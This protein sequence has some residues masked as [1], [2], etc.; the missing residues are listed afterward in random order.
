[1]GRGALNLIFLHGPPA[2][3]KLTIAKALSAELGWPVFHNHLVVD[4]LTSVFEFGSEPFVRLREDFWLA[5]FEAAATRGQSIIFTFAPERTVREDFARRTAE[6][7]ARHGGRVRFIRLTC[8]AE[9]L[10]ARVE[11]PDR[12]VH[13]KLRSR[14]LLAQLTAQGAFDC[15]PLP[16]ELSVDTSVAS[17]AEAAR[18]ISGH[19][20]STP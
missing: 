3:G 11:S 10:A 12:A 15:A 19:L 1:V 5:V 8:P 16:A 20:A 18:A 9:V 13:G 4:A 14:A 2:C 7:V 17:P 6:A